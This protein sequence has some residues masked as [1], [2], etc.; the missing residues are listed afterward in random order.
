MRK[1]FGWTVWACLSIVTD[2][3]NC[4]SERRAQRTETAAWTR[5]SDSE[6]LSESIILAQ[7]G[8]RKKH[9]MVTAKMLTYTERPNIK[10]KDTTGKDKNQSSVQRERCGP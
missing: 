7:C 8:L 1:Y 3:Q 5:F 6:W 9:K 10:D 4:D 2:G